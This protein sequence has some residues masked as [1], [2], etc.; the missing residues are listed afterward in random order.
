MSID[1]GYHVWRRLATAH[2][3]VIGAFATVVAACAE[4][5][6][7][8]IVLQRGH[9]LETLAAVYSPD[10]RILASSGESE[11]I[12]LWDPASGDLI[13]T[14]P[15]HPERV[16]GLAFSPDGKRLASSSTDGSVKI[17]DYRAG[18]L[19][20]DFTNHVGNWAR[21]VAFSADSRWLT[22]AT[23]DGNVSV[24]DAASGAV[25]R[26]LST[27]ARIADVLFTPDG[28]FVVT[29]SREDN[30]PLI[31]FWDLTTGQ[32]GLVLSH[33]N[34]LDAIAISRDGRWLASAGHGSMVKLWKLPE[35]RLEHV[36]T[37]GLEG[38]NVNIV[39]LSSDG[40]QV[41]AAG[42]RVATVWATKS[43]Q[44][45]YELRGH[46]DT[47]FCVGFSPDGRELATASADASI[48]LWNMRD[49]SLRRIIPRRPPHTPVSS[50]AFSADGRFEAMGTG[51][52]RVRVWDAQDGGF[53]YE[54]SGHEGAV[55]ALDFS[56]NGAWLFSGSADRT[57]RVWD[58]GY[59]T[60]SAIHPL[61]DREDAVG[62]LAVGGGKGLI[63]SASGPFGR[64]TL[65]HSIKLRQSHFDRPVR[66]FRGHA[67]NVR[68]VA[69]TSA[70]DL[71]ASAGAD[72]AVKLWNA[73]NGECLR[74][75]TNPVLAEVIAFSSGSQWLVAGMADG[76]VRVW[77]TN[78]LNTV[79]DWRA[80]LHPV[81]SLA[82]SANGRWLATA[83]ADHTVAVWDFESGREL[84]RF[85]NVTSQYLPIAFHP[86]QPVLA[87]AKRDEMSVHANVETGEILFQRVL[88]ADG[89][90]LAWNPAKAFYVASSRGDEHARVRF[91]DQLTP[92][93]PLTLYRRELRRETNLVAALASP[94][95]VL[96]P[97]NLELWW[98]RYPY[99]SAWL[100]GGLTVALLWITVR[101]RSGWLAERRRRAQ[102][103]ISRQLLVSQEAERKR[104]AA[105]MHDGLGQNLLIIKNR[106]Y[107]A[108]QDTDDASRSVQLQ[109]ISQ[110]V[111]RTIEEVRE[112]SHNLR[113]Y[114]LDRLGL[115]K[116]V[117]AMVKKVADS[118]SLTIQSAIAD[119]DGLFPP[120]GEI[121]FYRIVQECLNNI[122]KHSDAA[123]AHIAISRD[124][125]KVRMEIED[126]GH[127]F[128][129]HAT[130]NDRG[131]PHGFGLT[132]LG[133][134]VRILG[135]RFEC[136][137]AP[138]Q[139]TRLKF[140]I[141]IPTKHEK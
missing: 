83:S 33:S 53:Q 38:Q 31:R 119:L 105:E 2:G 36:L 98:H 110:T 77:E 140:E 93:Y 128:D 62:V 78:A 80:H 132:G 86:R 88:F 50:L 118:G 56:T 96:A 135:G 75:L 139:G 137:S 124:G 74:T 9:E 7:V 99:R 117:Q 69:F 141:P 27:Q 112:I 51:D 130:M 24:W 55:Y 10:G 57:L 103:N 67:A 18:R 26:S 64:S 109:D 76:T 61:F 48:R 120:E 92:V 22:A 115:T 12:R 20:H 133:E 21:Q 32:P 127:G 25:V 134:R 68:S 131:R 40:A 59:G 138:R 116:A 91:A 52:G 90:W 111:S 136:E 113:P 71:L 29:A 72:G 42:Q 1:C 66:I 123:L 125:G 46:E 70:S 101:L 79:R 122:I 60:I 58:M 126:D 73:R 81:Q 49:G 97:K 34:A 17:W 43:G 45:Q 44:R 6:P 106:L 30:S 8:E 89:E 85:T 23:Y 37:T 28:R 102:E 108:Q 5:S 35:G 95:P 107:L 63:A 100:Y 15:G 11:A 3:L 82:I 4:P 19:V 16:I 121:N 87:F 65:D 41:A 129:Y 14:L 47:V 13:K 104:I 114:Q 94:A 84:R 39:A 54:L